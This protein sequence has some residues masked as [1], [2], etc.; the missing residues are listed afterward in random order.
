MRILTKLSLLVSS[1]CTIVLFQN[2]SNAPAENETSAYPYSTPQIYFQ[3]TQKIEVEVYYEPGAEPFTGSTLQGKKYWSL[4][5][6]NLESIFQYRSQS[7]TIVSPLELSDMGLLSTQNKQ[8]WLATDI[9]ALHKQN[10]RGSSSPLESRFYVYF[11]NGYYSS[12][13]GPESGVIGVS[14]NGTPVIAIFKDVV[15]S[16][17]ATEDGAIPKYVE[18][19]TLIHEMGHALGLVN[20]GVPMS[21]AH[22]DT[23]HGV[24]TT[25]SDCVM[26][27][28]NEGLNDLKAFVKKR[29][30]SGTTIMWGPEVLQDVQNY[31][32]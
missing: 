11:L 21:K 12:G 22:Q 13:A 28:Q 15:K 20:N 5:Q 24:H 3:S 29:I 7:P 4:L 10:Y 17:G 16:T 26:Y 25:N 18:Q 6:E 2:C 9:L 27:W 19:S 31:S 23:A 14:I 1:I 8:A 30:T 32:K